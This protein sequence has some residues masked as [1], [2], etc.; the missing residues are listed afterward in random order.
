MI[1]EC[2]LKQPPLLTLIDHSY[3]E[4]A[5]SSRLNFKNWKLVD[6]DNYMKGNPPY[7]DFLES[8]KW[9]TSL[10]EWEE[11]KIA[12]SGFNVTNRSETEALGER[13]KEYTE[14]QDTMRE[15][16]SNS[17]IFFTEAAEAKAR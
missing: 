6:I 11:G 1:F 10:A 16:N 4:Y 3:K 14:Y 9:E 17:H 15:P 8:V 13:M 5:L 2:E 12:R 7:N